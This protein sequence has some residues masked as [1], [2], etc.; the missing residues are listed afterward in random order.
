MAVADH[1]L[2]VVSVIMQPVF[3][4]FTVKSNM[5]RQRLKLIPFEML[6]EGIVVRKKSVLLLL[7]KMVAKAK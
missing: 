2:D 6:N 4:D 7:V 1:S 3:D 5:C